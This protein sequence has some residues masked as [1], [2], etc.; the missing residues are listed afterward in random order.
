MDIKGKNINIFLFVFCFMFFG[1]GFKVYTEKN[2]KKEQMEEYNSIILSIGKNED[3]DIVKG[4]KRL[5]INDPCFFRA[6][7]RLIQHYQYKGQLDIALKFF[8]EMKNKYPDVPCFNNAIGRVYYYKK[9][10]DKAIEYLKII[11]DNDLELDGLDDIY[12]LFINSYLK[13]KKNKEIESYLKDKISTNPKNSRAFLGL[14]YFYS[15]NR[16]WDKSILMYNKALK[17]RPDLFLVYSVLSTVYY[18]KSD[19][20]SVIKSLNSLKKVAIRNNDV[21]FLANIQGNLGIIHRNMGNYELA[22]KYSKEALSNCKKTGNRK[23]EMRYTTTIGNIF[24]NIGEYEKSLLFL[25][26]ALEL[27]KKLGS[28]KSEGIIL[29][30]IGNIYFIIGNNK[31]ALEFFN[32]G[33]KM[34]KESG[35]KYG[36]G[37]INQ[38][39]G[40][41]YY[42]LKNY[43]EA[44]LYYNKALAIQ[45][46]IGNKKNRGY[47]P[48]DYW[49]CLQEFRR[50]E[51]GFDVFK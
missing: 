37:V 50:S 10:Y 8:L 20:K 38:S 1:S 5:I 9:N 27:N 42:D 28:K 13:K 30:N 40:R 19:F 45:K 6:Y 35:N 15:R 41:L 4:Y 7:K 21:I 51:K 22:L 14:G 26:K 25:N 31:K 24:Q 2:Q 3:K 44:L 48:G 16:I 12:L 34:A 43:P 29:G 36:E 32:R 23:S 47:N 39:I 18:Y 46:A 11:D 33:L 49:P 17:L